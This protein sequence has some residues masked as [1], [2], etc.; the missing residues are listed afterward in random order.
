MN[1]SEIYADLDGSLYELKISR[2]NK[3]NALTDA[4]YGS[5]VEHL[6][7]AEANPEIKVIY[8]RSDNEHFTAGNDL[9]DF[10]QNDFDDDSNVIQFLKII[11]RLK[12][13]LICAVGGAA[14]G[15]G[16]TLLLHC[17]LVY[18]C[19]D[20]KFSLPFIKLGLTPEGGSTK[21]LAERCGTA[22]ANDWLFTGRTFLAAEA[23][24]SGLVNGTFSDMQATWEGARK[25]AKSLS[26]NSL[27]VLLSTKELLKGEQVEEV[28]TVIKKEVKV[29]TE[30]LNSDES[31]AIMK[32]FLNK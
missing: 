16:T 5:L 14:V 32:A 24:Q 22:K 19:E 30:R 2:E 31:Q 10:V 3:M 21:L 6:Q 15:I 1:T 28:L 26:Q 4:M 8:L 18:A 27:E 17:D 25:I 29:F 11:T 23:E 13:P 20:T 9:Q 12:K 7:Y